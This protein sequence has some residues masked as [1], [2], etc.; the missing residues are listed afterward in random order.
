MKQAPPDHKAPKVIP[1]R[2]DLKVLRAF[3]VNQGQPEQSVLPVRKVPKAIL[4]S[5][6]CAV[7]RVKPVTQG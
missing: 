5:K 6:V 7:P 1:V 4:A 3:A 2:L